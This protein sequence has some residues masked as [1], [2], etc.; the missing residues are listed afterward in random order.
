MISNNIISGSMNKL[1]YYSS[2]HNADDCN[3][4]FMDDNQKVQKRIVK[5]PKEFQKVS[6]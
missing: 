5:K 3:V 6:L 2:I 4:T 1:A